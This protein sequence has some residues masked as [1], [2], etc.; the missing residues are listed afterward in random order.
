MKS[1]PI[2]G[3]SFKYSRQVSS[4]LVSAIYYIINL[5]SDKLHFYLWNDMWKSLLNQSKSNV[6]WIYLLEPRGKWLLSKA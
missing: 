5:K 3:E 1:M 4:S 6:S 2:P